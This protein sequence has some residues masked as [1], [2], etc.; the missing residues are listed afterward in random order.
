MPAHKELS[1]EELGEL[2]E[3]F[4][5]AD[6]DGGGSI[7]KDELGELLRTLR[8]HCTEEQL[9]S[10]FREAD[11]DG[12]GSIEFPEFVTVCSRSIG[13][14]Y[15][16]S[17][18]TQAF[19]HFSAPEDY[20]GYISTYALEDTLASYGV[21]S[22][23]ITEV[24]NTLDPDSTGS[25]FYTAFVNIISAGLIEDI[26]LFNVAGASRKFINAITSKLRPKL[27]K[28]NDVVVRKGELMREMFFVSNGCIQ[29]F[30]DDGKVKSTLNA[31]SYFGESILIPNQKR[32]SEH[33][34]R[35][36]AYSDVFVLHQKDLL[37]I[38]GQFPS[39]YK[40]VLNEVAKNTK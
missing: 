40:L 12:G 26:S 8:L 19:K 30:F 15:S 36:S 33:L 21:E 37:D 14:D 25:V 17:L 5:L 22:K 28:P 10:I 6:S 31:G 11:S 39:D 9:E 4:D 20:D 27:Y 32:I 35:A 1:E 3:I 29:I 7:D 16:A 23:K 2:K 34:I 24:L 13:E 18:L 38:G